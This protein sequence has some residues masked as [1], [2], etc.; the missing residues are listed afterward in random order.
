MLKI[1][2]AHCFRA[3]NLVVCAIFWLPAIATAREITVDA[4]GNGDYTRIPPAIEA[5]QNGDV[6]IIRPGTYANGFLI[7]GKNLTL[8]SVDPDDPEIVAQTIINGGSRSLINGN[9]VCTIA[10]LNFYRCGG[11]SLNYCEVQFVNNI[12][13]ENDASYGGGA[14]FAYYSPITLIGNQLIENRGGLFGSAIRADTSD[15]TL[16]GNYFRDNVTYI[17]SEG[18]AFSVWVE[19][20]GN[21]TSSNNIYIGEGVYFDLGGSG[22]FDGDLFHHTRGLDAIIGTLPPGGPAVLHNCILNGGGPDC[23]VT[24]SVPTQV[25]SSSLSGFHCGVGCN[26]T[27]YILRNLLIEGNQIGVSYNGYPGTTVDATFNCLYNLE[28]DFW[29]AFRGGYVVPGNLY[30]DPAVV[31]TGSWDYGDPTDYSDDVYTPGDNRLTRHSYCINA[32]DPNVPGAPDDRDIDG[33]VRVAGLKV[34]IGAYE[35]PAIGDMDGDGYVTMFDIDVFVLAL[36]SRAAHDAAFP[37]AQTELAG[38]AN[39]DGSFNNL[40]IDAFVECL[41]AGG[42]R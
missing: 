21:V 4:S 3:G 11:I 1:K 16:V 39:D 12:F 25:Y 37:L 20:G 15:V 31:R 28:Y 6:I 42:C 7:S 9:V 32:G 34:D 13:R 2:S 35:Y 33:F 8:R 24:T 23:A 27:D 22:A 41:L 18:S 17:S 5:A 14:I 29:R 38:D 36:S 30:T 40:D 26:A 10:G 19:S